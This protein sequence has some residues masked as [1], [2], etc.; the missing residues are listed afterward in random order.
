MKKFDYS[1]DKLYHIKD[2][3]N[4]YFNLINTIIIIIIILVIALIYTSKSNFE[5]E[6]TT[7]NEINI[8]VDT[9]EKEAIIET[10]EKS[11]VY[12]TGEVKNPGIYD[13]TENLRINDLIDLAGGLTDNANI[14]N[15]NLAQKLYDEDHIIILS[16]EEVISLG[17]TAE[18][19]TTN[20][21][22]TVVNINTANIE[23][24]KTINGVGDVTAEN[25]IKYREENGKFENKEDIKNV[26]GIGEK[27]YLELE[28]QIK[29]K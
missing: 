14:I 20:V 10:Y 29:V 12:I 22:N 19:S 13:L 27:T 8:T 23:E 15:I 24:L 26:T 6:L 18:S 28:S 25:I 2:L 5:K 9:S 7:E 11:Y 17:V 16:N 1:N 3:Y 4:N 21:E